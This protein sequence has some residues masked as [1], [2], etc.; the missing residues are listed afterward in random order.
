MLGILR[1]LG[2]AAPAA[3][4]AAPAAPAAAPRVDVYVVDK[5]EPAQQ[6]ERAAKRFALACAACKRPMSVQSC[7]RGV[8]APDGRLYCSPECIPPG[9]LVACVN[10]SM[11]AI[12]QLRVE[13]SQA[14]RELALAREKREEDPVE[15][16]K[17]EFGHLDEFPKLA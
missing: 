8:T 3:A 4:P 17:R 11:Q 16:V 2:L 15:A 9:L 7:P 10:K 5:A 1:F 13:L 14:Q 12:H 6:A